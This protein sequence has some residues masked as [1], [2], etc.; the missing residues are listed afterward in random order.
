MTAVAF[1]DLMCC[2]NTKTESEF[3][4]MLLQYGDGVTIRHLLLLLYAF[5]A[6]DMT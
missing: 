3:A 2:L 6:H 4:C 1:L 5:V